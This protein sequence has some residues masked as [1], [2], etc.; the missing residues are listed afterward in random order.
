MLRKGEV[1]GSSAA[2]KEATNLVPST[3]PHRICACKV[4]IAVF[5]HASRRTQNNSKQARNS[6]A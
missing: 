4:W 6:V 5:R 3:S 1:V 2:A